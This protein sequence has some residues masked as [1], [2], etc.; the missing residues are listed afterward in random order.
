MI[1][2]STTQ[3]PVFDDTDFGDNPRMR[4]QAHIQKLFEYYKHHVAAN[5]T[6][7]AFIDWCI[8][9]GA[10]AGP[11]GMIQNLLKNPIY[12][13]RKIGQRQ[14]LD[15]FDEQNKRAYVH[16]LIQEMIN[17][18]GTLQQQN[19]YLGSPRGDGV[20]QEKR[21]QRPQLAAR[22]IHQGGGAQQQRQVHQ[23][24]RVG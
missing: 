6:I 3:I 20:A 18:I 5:V 13:R 4:F 23:A 22:R 8:R 1:P 9:N 7:D 19:G 11:F 16:A 10:F 15:P 17:I 24:D 12:D 21:Q 14:F 2:D